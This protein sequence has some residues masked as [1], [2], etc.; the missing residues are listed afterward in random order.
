LL[1]NTLTM[2]FIRHTL[3]MLPLFWGSLKRKNQK[4]FV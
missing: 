2:T 3:G 1:G 4:F